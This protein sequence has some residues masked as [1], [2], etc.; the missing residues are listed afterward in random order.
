MRP[1]G[2]SYGKGQLKPDVYQLNVLVTR[3]DLTGEDRKVASSYHQGD[4]IRYLRGS[5]ALGLE[6]KSY[7]T[8]IETIPT[9]TKLRSE[10]T[11]GKFSNL[12]P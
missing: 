10:R 11:A 1:S 3:Q 4:S 2:K 5:E 12:Q 6:A 9:A 8:V 7:A